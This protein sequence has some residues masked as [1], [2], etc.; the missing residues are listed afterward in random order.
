MRILHILDHSVPLHSGYAFRTLAV[1]RHQR[2][3]GWETVHLTG[4]KQGVSTLLRETVDGYEFNRTP[5]PRGPWSSIPGLG[6]LAVMRAL[7]CRLNE[8]IR[9]TEPDILHAHSPVLNA[10]PTLRVGTR[11]GIPVL[12]EVRAS[13][14]DAAVSH[15][16]TTPGSLR[17]RVSRALETYAVKRAPA[18]TTICEGLRNDLISRGVAPAK[19]QVIPNAVDPGQFAGRGER[20]KALVE[21]LGLSGKTVLGFIGSFY[22]YEGLDLP[23][24]ALPE[25]L[26]REPDVRLL[27]VGGGPEE[28][29]LKA[30][31]G[32]LG[33]AGQVVFAGRVPHDQVPKYYDLADIMVYPRKSIRLTEL[34][35]PLKPL[36]AMA[37]GKIVVA[38]DVG[39]HRELIRDGE[40]GYLFRADNVPNLVA[41]MLQVLADRASWPKRARQARH[42]V[43]AERTWAN[44]VAR[45]REV[46][47]GLLGLAQRQATSAPVSTDRRLTASK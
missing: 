16:S 33:V 40:T 46:Y 44:S 37:Q 32:E 5:V 43:E 4:P 12:Y 41:V 3:L 9:E 11:L 26:A 8:L 13:W 28:A 19:I 25:L 31:A 20:D 42:F 38:S 18:V 35:T 47:A 14:E 36:E 2:A 39:G 17:Y 45:Y 6:E 30:L 21:T 27:L 15:G 29:R 7:A 10:L 24:R 1:L 34:V 23:L 22:G